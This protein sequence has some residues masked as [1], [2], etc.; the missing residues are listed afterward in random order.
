ML[1]QT[2]PEPGLVA[3]RPAGYKVR[4]QTWV[5]HYH[6]F[7]ALPPDLIGN[8][9][10]EVSFLDDDAVI[11]DVHQFGDE[12]AI[13]SVR[14]EMQG[15]KMEA[16]ETALLLSAGAPGGLQIRALSGVDTTLLWN[17]GR[18]IG[19]CFEDSD[20]KY[21]M[22]GDIRP[23]NLAASRGEQTLDV[24]E[25]MQRVL[26]SVGMDFRHVVRTWFYNDRILDWYAEFNKVRAAFF[27]RHGLAVMP[28]STGIGV[29]NP[30]GA[31]LTAKAIAVMPKTQRVTIRRVESPLQRE[32]ST[33]GSSFSRAMEV[34]DPAARVLYISGTAS[35][36][37]NGQTAH[38]GNALKQVEKT[39]E[40]AEAILE[41][42]GMSLSDTIRAIGYFRHREHIPLWRQYCQSRGLA[43][44]PIV[45]T[46]CEVCRENLLFEIELDAAREV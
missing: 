35:I 17:E 8:E 30:I 12:E 37:S 46:E 10:Q 36:E 3:A 18:V 25:T 40:V 44:I 5:D 4:H 2:Q 19:R 11:A 43:P 6:T 1:I 41:R 38:L 29:S 20:A 31:A 14:A 13:A 34:A 45:V 9:Q 33:Y 32:A 23:G 39:M 21:C 26:A 24:L 27:D 42:N 7:L 28:A 16:P 15:G 22:L